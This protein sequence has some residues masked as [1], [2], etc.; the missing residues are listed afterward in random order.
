[1]IPATELGYTWSYGAIVLAAVVAA[2]PKLPRELWSKK[3]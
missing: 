2:F 3:L 1:M